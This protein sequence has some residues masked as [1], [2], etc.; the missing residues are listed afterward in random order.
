VC[1]AADFSA[2]AIGDVDRSGFNDVV[3]ADRA[4]GSPRIWIFAN[5]PFGLE[6]P[7]SLPSGPQPVAVAVL[8][9]N[10]DR[11]PDLVVVHQ[12]GTVMYREGAGAGGFGPQFL[13]PVG[14]RP[15]ALVMDDVTG[16]GAVD[17]ILSDPIGASGSP[18]P[19]IAILPQTTRTVSGIA[20]AAVQANGQAVGEVVYLNDQGNAVPDATVTDPSGQFAIFNVP[21]GP[22][23][24]RLVNGG[25]GSRFLHAYAD[26]VT[27]TSF[28]VIRGETTTVS[29]NGVTV[30]AVL[31]PVGEV[32]IQFLGTQRAT[33]SNPIIFDQQGNATGGADYRSIIEANSDY[34][35]RL[36]K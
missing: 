31:R 34:V 20:V 6:T 3:V 28:P 1:D 17:A 7:T 2:A 35:I 36:S 8:D 4:A 14:G 9:L 22:I 26:A 12:D 21:P 25:L 5:G 16:D 33:S 23:W 15:A 29:I 24:L 11:S 19:R 30:D 32:Q 10:T 18:G 13:F 27:N